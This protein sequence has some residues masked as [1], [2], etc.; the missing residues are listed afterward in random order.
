MLTENI[1]LLIIIFGCA[2]IIECQT[3]KESEI[4][5]GRIPTGEA[6]MHEDLL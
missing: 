6:S 3:V 5:S 2:A 1:I 4:D